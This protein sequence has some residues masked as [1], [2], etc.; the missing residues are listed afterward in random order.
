MHDSTK[1]LNSKIGNTT[2]E[3]ELTAAVLCFI[4]KGL[5]VSEDIHNQKEGKAL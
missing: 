1:A 4:N 5:K 3:L 2:K